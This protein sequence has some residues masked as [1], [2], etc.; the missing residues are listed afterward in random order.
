MS[1][2]NFDD[3]KSITLLIKEK[4]QVVIKSIL[5]FM[6]DR[7]KNFAAFK[8]STGI[9]GEEVLISFKVRKEFYATILEKL[10]YNDVQIMTKDK[11]TTKYVEDKVEHK[12]QKLRSRGW[13]ELSLQTKQISFEELEILCRE[14]RIKEVAK[15]AKGGI[16]SSGEII[17][18]AKNILSETTFIAID[19]LL[20]DVE[21]NISN[22]QNVIDE[23]L[24]I[25]TDSDL[26]LFQ[27]REEMTKAGESAIS[28]STESEDL[29]H[30]LIKIANNTKLENILNLKAAIYL[31]G[32]VTRIVDQN[33]LLD[34]DKQID[35][36]DVVK[37]L[38]TRW[39]MIAFDS[40]SNKLDADEKASFNQLIDFIESKR[41]AA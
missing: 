14:G 26:K 19:N 27:K 31:S 24:D 1:F 34:E 40:I 6:K 3:L 30:N 15:E 35:T 17:S 8:Y 33:L 29:Y 38:N 37:L 13:K 2:N 11:S 7:F 22:K 36:P 28:L 21:E 18:K 5:D 9:I 23:L 16:G 10:A 41:N 32:I 25:A 12:K 4:D 20:K 39:L